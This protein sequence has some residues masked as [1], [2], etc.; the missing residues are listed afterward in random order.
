MSKLLGSGPQL[1]EAEALLTFRQAADLFGVPYW[2]I[3]RAARDGLIPTFTLLNSRR[4]VR[5]S[6]IERALLVSP[7]RTEGSV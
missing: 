5:R 6:D 2:K 7:L 3:Q 1:R 4:Y